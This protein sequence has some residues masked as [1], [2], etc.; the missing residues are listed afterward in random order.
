ML[1]RT[2]T[3]LVQAGSFLLAAVLLYLALRGVDF[4]ILWE[5][6]KTAQYIWL[7]PLVAVVLV[8]HLIRA[9]RWQILLEALPERKDDERKGRV[10]IKTAF[11]S[12]MI[13][14]M[15]NY[16][17]PRIGEL[18]RTGNLAAQEKLR[19]S[20]VFGTV[21]AERVLDVLVLLLAIASLFL[22]FFDQLAALDAFL[23]EPVTRRLGEGPALGI[24][25]LIVGIFVV[26]GLIIRHLFRRQESRLRAFWQDRLRPV[27]ASFRDGL[28]TLWHSPRRLMI[29]VLTV[30]MWFLYLLMAYIPLLLLNMAGPWQLSLLDGWGL[31]VLGSLGIAVPSPGGTGSYH[32]ITI[33]AMVYLFAV[34]QGPAA[35]Y[36][37][38]THGAQ[39]ILYVVVGAACIMLQ[40]TSWQ[41][42]WQRTDAP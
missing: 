33:Q 37:I 29:A 25:L 23:I 12:L 9:W 31:M 5:T 40:G 16:V 14:Y 36:A 34:A 7:L 2:R 3:I 11:Y 19:F 24:L 4:S 28:L 26:L 20:S 39:M 30:A 1:P 8:S 15:I 42:L 13:G 17:A 32:Y 18:V 38:L 6:L 10:S 41:A 35:A 22:V 27:L 21:V